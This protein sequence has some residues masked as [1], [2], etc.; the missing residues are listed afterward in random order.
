MPLE[1]QTST[2]PTASYLQSAAYYK[3]R[4][5]RVELSARTG[6]PPGQMA[7]VDGLGHKEIR[8]TFSS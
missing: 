8:H 3:R 5:V 4:L 7:K 1:K 2:E 6:P